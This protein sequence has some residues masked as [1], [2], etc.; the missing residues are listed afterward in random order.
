MK[1]IFNQ[2]CVFSSLQDNYVSCEWLFLEL[3][4]LVSLGLINYSPSLSSNLNPI[5][6]KLIGIHEVNT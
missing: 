3:R 2:L 6:Y 4:V 1:I 5:K